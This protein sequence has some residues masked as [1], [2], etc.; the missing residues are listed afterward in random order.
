[1]DRRDFVRISSLLGTGMLLKF[2]GIALST[3]QPDGLLESMAKSSL[4]DKI[5][6]LIQL[7][8]GNDGLNMVIPINQY[9]NYYNLRPNIAIPQSGNRHYITLDPSLPA[10]KQVGLHP[11]MVGSKA[12]YDNGH[13]AIIQNVSYENMNGSHFRS[14][15]VWYM[16]GNYDDY[17]N[18]GW[19]G[20]YFEH[21]YPDYPTGYPNAT[22]PDPLALEMGTGVSLAFHR[23]QGI[24]AG[25]SIQNPDAFYNLINSVGAEE[26][27]NFPPT[28]AGDEIEYI[29]QIERQSNNY[30][31]R[32]RDVYDAGTNSGTVYPDLYPYI[33]PSGSLNNPLAPQLKIISRLISGGIGT[34]IFLCRIGGFDTHANQ[35]INN[36]TT[37]GS[38]AALM[39]HISSAV[40]AFYDDLT[41]LGLADRVLT[42]TFSEFG[43]RVASN[44][45]YGTDH[46]NA[47]PMLVY[48]TCLNPGV[49]GDNPDLQNLQNGN[50][51]LQH[52]YRQVFTSVVKD[53]FGAPDA[54][55]EHVKFEN[56]VAN[57][58]DYVACKE[59]SVTE[60]F[61]E[62]LWLKCY[63]NPTNSGI[64]ISYILKKETKV[65]I[66]VK[67]ISGRTIGNI[68]D[69]P[70]V[71]GEHVLEF[72]LSRY[73]DGTYFV[74]LI[75]NDSVV[76]TEKVILS[77]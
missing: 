70:T 54:A 21:Y 15:D 13:M 22:V 73:A 75:A 37:M 58:V 77:K 34:K 63:P 14:R 45:S 62:N 74:T 72:N 27:T 46:G 7:H 64:S 10:N 55:I 43:R 20:R 19:M 9:G 25:L 49:Y 26:P 8:G 71:P 61:K 67:D 47:A 59:L 16:G 17:F 53:W 52:D 24:P 66:E 28:H 65:H 40:K 1:M 6:V 18:S 33:A 44:A 51:P 48:G 57:R 23:E 42:M 41:N 60:L 36:N 32:L 76:L 11:D 69:A 2:N 30:A 31:E 50:I 68:P 39:Y 5:L 38:H 56:F 3:V 35:V 29:M 12:M 4:N